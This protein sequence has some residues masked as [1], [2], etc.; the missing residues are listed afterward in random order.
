MKV[1]RLARSKMN[2]GCAVSIPNRSGAPMP[3][4][5]ACSDQFAIAPYDAYNVSPPRAQPA[6][7]AVGPRRRQGGQKLDLS[8]LGL[9][10]HLRNTGR[11]GGI[12][13]DREDVLRRAGNAT[14]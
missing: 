2:S 4:Q 11:A 3:A 10:Q 14:A 1:N 7:G 12:T 6:N 8:S 5:D 9:Q 13:V